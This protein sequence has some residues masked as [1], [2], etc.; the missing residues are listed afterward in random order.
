MLTHS[1]AEAMKRSDPQLADVIFPVINGQEINNHPD[2]A[3][4]RQIINFFDWPLERAE[5]YGEAFAR[6]R[7]LVKPEREKQK[8]EGGR[9]KW[10]QFLRPRP[11]LYARAKD[12]PWCFV[13]SRLTKHLNFITATPDR[14][15]LDTIYVLTT[16]RWS[17][18]AVVQSTLHEVWARKYSGALETRLR[19]SPTDCFA[20][21][22]FPRDPAHEAALAAI[23]EAYHEHRRA[24][25]RDL[26][27]G[28]TD[29]YNL[30][31]RPDLTAELITMERGDR[32]TIPGAEGFTRLLRLRELHIALDTAVL[33]AY[34]WDR[35]SDFGPP[36]QLRHG[37]HA[38]DNL[39]ENDRTRFTLHP[40]ARR[41]VLARL[42]KLNHQRAAA[43]MAATL[44][45]S[46]TAKARASKT[47]H[48]VKTDATEGLPLF[49]IPPT[50]APAE[51][52]VLPNG[53]RPTLTKTSELF[54]LLIPALVQEASGPLSYEDL[55]AALSFL[56]DPPAQAPALPG[57]TP[58]TYSAWRKGFPAAL[59][60][61]T[62]LRA[63]LHD[64]I[65]QRH[66]LNLRPSGE[67]FEFFPGMNF[68]AVRNAWTITDAKAALAMTSRRQAVT[69]VKPVMPA[70]REAVPLTL[71]DEWFKVA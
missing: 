42:L 64:L 8:D 22:P 65:V 38:L 26:W 44:E 25:M 9:K 39:P 32:A 21:F 7:D 29:L 58:K 48:P 41:E 52:F 19:Y 35:P 40:E 69:E 27:L 5:R 14:V 20:T 62:A 1:E 10:W 15:F 54:L 70:F 67:S 60:N 49:T 56:N 47:K 59:V 23:G 24:L 13:A 63:A 34:G 33:A 51:S 2:H 71:L 45:A 46:N 68:Q 4:G 66:L 17:D 18:Y 37:F 16:D 36:L 31:H 55:L 11:E 3:P 61:P 43:E 53:Q 6:V 12:L 30:F 50:P 28:L 57:N